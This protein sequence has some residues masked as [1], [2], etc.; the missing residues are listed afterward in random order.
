M[1]L[2]EQERINAEKA[3]REEESRLRREEE[4]KRRDAERREA[5]DEDHRYTGMLVYISRGPQ[6]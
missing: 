4:S 1:P 2:Y 6:I 5:R 3:K